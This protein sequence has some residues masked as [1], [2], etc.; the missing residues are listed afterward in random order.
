MC[1]VNE[2]H[3]TISCVTGVNDLVA[4]SSVYP[5]FA[6]SSDR[7]EELRA[8]FLM[9]VWMLA[10]RI[11]SSKA[12]VVS[13]RVFSPGSVATFALPIFREQTSSRT[14]NIFS[15]FLLL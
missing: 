2:M 5:N 9:A 12:S 7:G 1:M 11:F 8:D 6:A 14:S 15:V 4:S 10:R 3:N 13:G